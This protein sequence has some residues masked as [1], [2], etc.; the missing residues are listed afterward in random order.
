MERAAYLISGIPGAGKTTVARLLAGRFARGVHIESDLLQKMII[1]GGQ[2]PAAHPEGAEGLSPDDEEGRRQLA[3]REKHCCLL[4]DSFFEAGFTPV[5]DDVVIGTWLE[6]FQANLRSRPLLF[7]M[8]APR[9]DVVRERDATRP[10]KHVFDT[11][12]YLDAVVRNETP[13]DGLWIDSSD[14]SAEETVDEIVRRAAEA[15][16]D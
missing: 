14:L 5:I 4:A 2:W 13:K 6:A 9:P 11:W 3:L 7:V 16:L 10:E 8:L 15:Q 1:S 12:G